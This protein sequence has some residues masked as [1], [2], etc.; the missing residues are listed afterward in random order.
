MRVSAGTG[1]A[2]WAGGLVLG[3]VRRRAL[4]SDTGRGGDV[5]GPRAHGFSTRDRTAPAE[6][7]RVGR[8]RLRREPVVDLGVVGPRPTAVVPFPGE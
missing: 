4:A 1:P 8:G 3:R 6:L 2:G 5:T 7:G